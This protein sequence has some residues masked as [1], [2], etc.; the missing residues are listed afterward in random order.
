MERVR[1]ERKKE[2]WEELKKGDGK[3]K[4]REETRNMGRRVK[5]REKGKR[6]DGKYILKEEE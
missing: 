3:S 4:L 6:R 2:K 5:E 1:C